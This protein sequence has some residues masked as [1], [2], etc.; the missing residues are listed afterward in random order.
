MHLLQ[1]TYSTKRAD[2]S[3]LAL[4]FKH[5]ATPARL[6]ANPDFQSI[7]S[8]YEAFLHLLMLEFSSVQRELGE[9]LEK[10][11]E[12]KQRSRIILELQESLQERDSLLRR[13]GLL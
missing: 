8:Q 1:S 3:H 12:S 10:D 6:G 4:L 7:E 5:G 2:L 13:K 9:H 11:I